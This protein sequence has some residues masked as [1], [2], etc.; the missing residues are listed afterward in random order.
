MT[1]TTPLLTVSAGGPSTAADNT[2]ISVVTRVFFPRRR[3]NT[4]PSNAATGSDDDDAAATEL[5]ALEEGQGRGRRAKEGRERCFDWFRGWYR[6]ICFSKWYK[7]IAYYIPILEWLP[8]Y[9]CT[10]QPISFC[11]GRKI[12]TRA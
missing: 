12:L 3:R 8:S 2:R 9:Q 4:D 5:T 10:L 11:E 1:E 6:H 7:W